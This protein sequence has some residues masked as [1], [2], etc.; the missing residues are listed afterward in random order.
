M[1][2]RLKIESGVICSLSLSFNKDGLL[3]TFF[4]FVGGSATY[5]A[6]YDD[7]VKARKSSSTSAMS[8][9]R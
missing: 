6:R 1:S 4:Q 8:R 3:G 7:A 2:I 5:V 9:Y